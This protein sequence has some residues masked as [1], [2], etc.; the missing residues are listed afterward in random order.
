[1][2][3]NKAWRP[4]LGLSQERV[5]KIKSVYPV[6]R[7]AEQA[8]NVPWQAIASIWMRESGSIAPPRHRQGGQMQFDPPLTD[9]RMRDL[10]T[11]YSVLDFEKR[12]QVIQ[13]GQES[14]PSAFILAGCFLQ[15]KAGGKI[16]PD[17]P[18]VLLK[19]AFYSYNGR[20]YGG[21]D[22]SPY[23]MNGYDEAHR[24]MRVRGTV[25]DRAGNKIWVDNVDKNPG[26]LVMYRQL[27]TWFPRAKG[28]A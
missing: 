14:L 27:C 7:A 10:L 18:E 25:L 28:E 9:A 22:R 3:E 5:A 11:R 21:A 6:L 15:H 17:S 12:E 26:A 24:D 20:K 19:E 13:S 23:V 2:T 1:M 4:V 16:R 8:T